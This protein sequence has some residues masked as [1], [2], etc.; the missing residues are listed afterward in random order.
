MVRFVRDNPL[1]LAWIHSFGPYPWFIT[2][3]LGD[4]VARNGWRISELHARLAPHL[5]RLV[6]SAWKRS[7][8]WAQ[9]N[10]LSYPQFKAAV[11]G[12]FVRLD[13][14]LTSAVMLDALVDGELGKRGIMPI[15][16]SE[17]QFDRD[18]DYHAVIP[19]TF[20]VDGL[21]RRVVDEE[22]LFDLGHLSDQSLHLMRELS[23]GAAVVEYIAHDVAH[24]A[25]RLHLRG[26][27]PRLLNDRKD[28]VKNRQVRPAPYQ[29]LDRQRIATF[30]DIVLPYYDED[31]YDE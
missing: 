20:V 23:K 27:E 16:D 4:V 21:D 5:P 1:S 18:V 9:W 3:F 15:L 12:D 11:S 22:V 7:D 28:A 29:R 17:V 2:P 30:Y 24:A 14:A 25:D 8:P 6:P 19:S 26:V 31:E 10:S 13:K